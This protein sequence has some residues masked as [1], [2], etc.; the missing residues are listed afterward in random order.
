MSF[1]DD[2]DKAKK[3]YQTTTGDKRPT[4]AWYKIGTGLTP[5]LK[6]L[7]D[8]LAA[9]TK[10]LKANKIPKGDQT[11][12]DK[13]YAELKKITLKVS[14]AGGGFSAALFKEIKVV[15]RKDKAQV[16]KAAAR[17]DLEKDFQ[18]IM[19][20]VGKATKAARAEMKELPDRL[21]TKDKTGKTTLREYGKANRN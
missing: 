19:T 15:D 8:W 10:D 21:D 17:D 14:K 4:G 9:F 2:W 5:A 18:S 3:K 11:A 12:V 1:A 6:E 7:D 13:K 16:E 20:A